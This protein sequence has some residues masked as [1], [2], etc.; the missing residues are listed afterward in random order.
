MANRLIA[1]CIGINDYQHVGK[2]KGCVPDANN[3]YNYLEES[4]KNAGFDFDGL[5]L[6]DD[7]ATKGNIVK[8]FKEHLMA[9][10]KPEDVAVFYFS[11]H[12]AEEDADSIFAEVSGDNKPLSTLVCYDSRN[13]EGVTDLADKELR[14]LIHK[15]TYRENGEKT[16][17]FVLITDSCHSGSVTKDADADPDMVARLTT[18]SAARKWDDFIFAKELPRSK[19]ENTS[20]KKVMPQG[21]HIHLSACEASELAYEV[22]GSGVFTSTLLEVLKRGAGKVTYQSLY[23]RIRFFIKGRFPQTPTIGVVDGDAQALK[24]YFLG[25]AAE[26]KGLTASMVYNRSDR[27]FTLD[28]GA[29]HGLPPEGV[30]VEVLNNDGT[31]RTT[32]TVNKVMP[33]RSFVTVDDITLPREDYTV[34]LKGIFRNPTN[35]YLDDKADAAAIKALQAELAKTG[36]DNNLA[37]VT[38]FAAANYILTVVDGKY[39]IRR[40][41]DT[42]PLTRQ[43][44]TDDKSAVKDVLTYFNTIARWEFYKAIDNPASKLQPKPPVEIVVYRVKDEF[45]DSQDVLIAP[46]QKGQIAVGEGE[47]LRIGVTNKSRKKL[48]CSLLYFDNLFSI[49]ADFLEG[50]VDYVNPEENLWVWEKDVFSFEFEDYQKAHNWEKTLHDF[51]LIISTARFDVNDMEQDPVPAPEGEHVDFKAIKRRRAMSSED[52]WAVTG[53]T[54]VL[55]NEDYKA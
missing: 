26:N 45:D 50:K 11:G 40:P 44:A 38:D 14:Y 17:H 48:Y 42:R 28:V 24:E 22:R 30:T 4:A 46:D 5:L 52:D 37:I 19:F 23:N 21:E 1:L 54:F 43:V 27:Q 49:S 36:E 33:E 20:I 6:T 39:T 25:G 10:A 53:V 9:K 12:G 32:G 13:P 16:P 31:V 3:I 47:L 15:F 55:K 35:I 41:S 7:K 29:I 18:Q 8:Q 34:L 2:L 51:K